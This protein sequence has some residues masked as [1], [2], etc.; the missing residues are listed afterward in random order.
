MA[1]YMSYLVNIAIYSVLIFTIMVTFCKKL[2][3]FIPSYDESKKKWKT[4]VEIYS[5]LV[6]VVCVSYI[7]REL[8]NYYI[9]GPLGV[10]GSP[11]KFAIIILGSPIFSQQPNLMKKIKMIWKN[12]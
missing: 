4:V 7:I 2:D 8:L 12:V 6:I 10:I 3:Q 9:K 1:F 5:Q 11:D